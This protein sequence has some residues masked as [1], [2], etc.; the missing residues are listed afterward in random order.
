MGYFVYNFQLTGIKIKSMQG[1]NK[2]SVSISSMR[3][4]SNSSEV[5]PSSPNH[6]NELIVSYSV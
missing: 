6:V 4:P 2:I 1:Y 5:T 3:E